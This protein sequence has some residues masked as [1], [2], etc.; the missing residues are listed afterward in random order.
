[1]NTFGLIGT[2]I[3]YSLSPVMHEHCFRLFGVAAR[4]VLMPTKRLELP[5]VIEQ[6]RS[7][8]VNG[9]NVTRPFKTDVLPFLDELSTAADRTGAVNCI[10]VAR[11]KLVGHN[12]DVDGISYALVQAGITLTGKRCL[13]IGYGGAARAAIAFL[14]QANVAT[15]TIAG[16][17]PAALANLGH[18]MGAGDISQP[19]NTISLTDL[20]SLEAYDLVINATPVGMAPHITQ[21]ILPANLLYSDLAVLDMVHNPVT[22]KLLNDAAQAGCTMANGVDMLIGQGLASQAVWSTVPEE[23]MDGAILNQ[24]ELGELKGVML[25]AID[26]INAAYTAQ[27]AA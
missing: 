2:T 1:M 21:S 14:L 19:I 8:K 27:G 23:R 11:G 15:L 17:R 22:T 9:L 6:L 5:L 20:Q 25:D 12:T 16:R 24:A 26:A 3:N 10:A 18:E 7:G 4:Y 13:I